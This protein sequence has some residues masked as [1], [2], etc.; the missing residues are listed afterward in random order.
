MVS[1]RLSLGYLEGGL[2]H[3][4][5]RRVGMLLGRVDRPEAWVLASG[6]VRVADPRIGGEHLVL[7]VALIGRMWLMTAGWLVV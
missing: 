1:R 3:L 7:R 6:R 5:G 4:N 2:R